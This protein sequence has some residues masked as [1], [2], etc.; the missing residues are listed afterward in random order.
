MMMLDTAFAAMLSVGT[1]FPTPS[2]RPRVVLVSTVTTTSSGTPLP[3]RFVSAELSQGGTQAIVPSRAIASELARVDRVL[4][5]AGVLPVSA[6][7]QAVVDAIVAEN[8]PKA[9][10]KRILTAR[11]TK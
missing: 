2:R 4:G 1:D 7:A 6:A 3:E 5:A 9:T 10:S 8:R 11:S